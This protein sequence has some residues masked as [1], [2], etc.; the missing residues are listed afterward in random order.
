MRAEGF[1][2]SLEILYEGLGIGKLLFLIQRIIFFAV[3]FFNLWSSKPWIRIGI[4]P[5]EY[6]SETL[7]HK[8]PLLLGSID[9]MTNETGISYYPAHSGIAAAGTDLINDARLRVPEEG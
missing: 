4:Q 8:T 1:S 9:G 2:C 3:N 5:N 6:G 7:V